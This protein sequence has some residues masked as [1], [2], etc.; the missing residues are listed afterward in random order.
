MNS[1]VKMNTYELNALS[2][3]VVLAAIEVHRTM[4]PG[5]LERVYEDCLMEEF[6]IRNIKAL[7]QVNVPLEYKGKKLHSNYVIDIL[8]DNEIV[9]ELK[10]VEEIHPVFEAQ[11]LSYLK[12]ADKRLGFLL[13]FNVNVMK[14]GINRFV[15]G[16]GH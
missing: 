12:L 4:G 15:N 9:V 8:V 3:Q 2:R 1:N 13:N 7:R 6:E 14:N 5:L 11:L 16:I 10:A